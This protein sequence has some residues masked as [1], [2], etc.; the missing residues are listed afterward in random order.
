METAPV[1]NVP[2]TTSVRI[3]GNFSRRIRLVCIMLSLACFYFLFGTP[4]FAEQQAPQ[5]AADGTLTIDPEDVR[6]RGPAIWTV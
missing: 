5:M 1:Q 2:A 6:K 4:A 3:D